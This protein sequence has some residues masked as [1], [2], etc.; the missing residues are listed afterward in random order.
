MHFLHLDKL[1]PVEDERDL[2]VFWLAALAFRRSHKHLDKEL[3]NY[4]FLRSNEA[5]GVI[6]LDSIMDDIVYEFASLETPPSNSREVN[7]AWTRLESMVNK[8]FQ[9]FA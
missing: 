8:A 2:Y 9:K 6:H 1:L 4:V 5:R 7:K 3:A